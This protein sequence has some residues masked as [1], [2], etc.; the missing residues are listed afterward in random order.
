MTA[1]QWLLG[2]TSFNVLMTAM[3]GW[4]FIRSRALLRT[5][6]ATSL[7]SLELQISECQSQCTLLMESHKRLQSRYAMRELRDR[8]K[9]A[10]EPAESQPN[11]ADREKLR[12]LARSRGLM[13]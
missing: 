3:A 13:R 7:A 6:S 11:G 10:P 12:E 8:R 9:D 5:V 2:L 1:T 4:F